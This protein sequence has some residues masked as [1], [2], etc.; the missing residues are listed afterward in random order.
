MMV[1]QHGHGNVKETVGK[2]KRLRARRNARC[3][4]L[5]ALGAHDLRR[6][7]GGHAAIGRLIGAGSRPNVQDRSRVPERLPD[8]RRNP[9]I[10]ASLTAV[11]LPDRVVERASAGVCGHEQSIAD[12]L[13]PSKPAPHRPRTTRSSLRGSAGFSFLT[14]PQKRQPH[15]CRKGGKTE[16]CARPAADLRTIRGGVVR[17][18][19]GGHNR[20]LLC[21]P[22]RMIATCQHLGMSEHD[23]FEDRVRALAD[24]ISRS[25]QRMADVDLE[26]LAE[27]YGVDVPAPR[28]APPA[29]G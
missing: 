7:D 2:R 24:Q 10:G 18:C 21:A 5:R 17:P 3:G 29:S 16:A 15:P 13:G 19:P 8:A 20:L 22:G 23:S 27:G 12:I 11:G 1:R 25:M 4:I 14:R 9:G 26:Q 28:P 6:L